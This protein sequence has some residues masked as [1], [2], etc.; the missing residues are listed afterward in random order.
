M[1]TNPTKNE[2]PAP[3]LSDYL[4]PEALQKKYPAMLSRPQI[5]WILRQ[6][7]KNGLSKLGAVVLLSRKYYIHE[8]LFAQWFAS[9][10]A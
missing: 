3:A 6:R 10:K 8:N 7:D 4:T 9:Q 1:Q 2:N 5:T